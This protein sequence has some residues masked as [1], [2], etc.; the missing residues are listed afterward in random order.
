MNI[1]IRHAGVFCLAALMTSSCSN[2][3]KEKVRHLER[4]D[5][6][7][8]EKRD[9]FAVV[10][11]ASAVKID[12]KF[13]EARFKLAET[14]QRLN[15]TRA[16]F[17]E[18][19]RAADALP[20]DRK[21]QIK[22]TEVLLLSGRFEDAKARA[23]ALLKKNPKDVDALLLHANAMSALRDPAGAITEIEE[24]LKVNPNSSTAFVNLGAV[25]MQTG[26]AREAE[27]AFRK[28]IE[29]EPSSV[30]AKLA[31]AN[32]LWAA[33]RAAEAEAVIKEAL[34]KEPQHLLANRMLG[35][36]Y[37]A[38]RRTKEAEAPLKVVADVSKTP[39][40]QLQLADYYMSTGRNKDAVALLTPISAAPETFAD[41][42]ARLA[43]IDYSEGRVPEAHKRLDSVLARIPKH[44]PVLVMKT[45]WLTNEN[46]LD[47]ALAQGKA[48]T[49]ADPQSAE[50]HFALAVVQ[51]RRREVDDAV[52]SYQEVLRLNPRAVAA[53]VEL[54]R[55]SLSTGD[56]AEAVRYA[57]SARRAEPASGDAR[58]ALARSLIAAG[59]LTRAEA[60]VAELL[61]GAP[62]SAAVHSLNGTLQATRKNTAAARA[63]YTRAVELTPGFLEALGGLTYLDLEAKNPAGAI[64]RL[65]AE[66]AK[67]PTSAPLLALLARAH[68][69]AGDEAKMEQ[70]LRRAVTVDPLYTPGYNVLAQLYVK[71]RRIDEARAEFEGI[72]KRNPS[73]I[74][75]RTMSGMLLE[76]QGKRDE[77]RKSYEATVA[78]GRNAPVAANNLAFIYAE[79]GTNLD[80][81]LQ[82]ASS[83][84]QLMPN[85]P[86]VDDTLGWI[87]YKKDLPSQA[88]RPLQDSLAK[89]P[90]SA[91]TLYHLGMTYAKL[92]DKAK[93]RETLER[94]LKLDPKVGGDTARKALAS[95]S[96]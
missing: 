11:Y 6:Y 90:N 41:A 31:Y 81:A 70:A 76:A 19:V 65:E 61:K 62:N 92:G 3:E 17:P 28:A 1:A 63:S 74:G 45:R 56:E 25:R 77:A 88:V 57:E 59:N 38:T 94:A 7:A 64:A 51:D 46:K 26:D 84:K 37:V 78:A 95:V 72:V 4:G 24:A 47:E 79:E 85:D 87:Y 33:Q 54:S 18:Y 60:E 27:A 36:L 15:N 42:E 80:V 20:D 34:V 58:I 14:Y 48:A 69:A 68:G 73:A 39:A 40:A 83:A 66:I 22:A 75:A 89:R 5:Q 29:L 43:A 2:P 9:E 8:A 10:E 93:A 13:G 32:F 52:K 96:Q 55:L 91:E 86:N 67:Q 12:P 49:A 23:A 16:A 82:L 44:A 53:Q 21:A 71:Q 50:A 30:D 35:V